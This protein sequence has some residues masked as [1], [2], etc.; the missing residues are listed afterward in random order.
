MHEWVYQPG[1]PLISVA[2][3]SHKNAMGA[4]QER[5]FLLNKSDQP[6]A[7]DTIW[8]VPLGFRHVE[9]GHS[10][11]DIERSLL[12]E[13]RG[14]IELKGDPPFLANAAADGYYRVRYTPSALKALS[15]D[16]QNSLTVSE[17]ASLLSDQFALA[18][19]GQMPLQDYLTLTEQF[20][21]EN[22][23]AVIGVI[24]A[25]LGYLDL[26]VSDKSRSLFQAFVRDRLGGIK[27]KLGWAETSPDE[28]DL[29]KEARADVL[30]TLGTIGQD[31]TTIKEARDAFKKY[32]ADRKSLAPDLVSPVITIVAYNGSEGD[33]NALSN[34]WHSAT[35]PSQERQLLLSLA[36]FRQPALIEKTLAMALTSAV[37]SQD[38]PFLVSGIARTAAGRYFAWKFITSHW[39]ALNQHFPEH[40][41]PRMVHG[42][43][44]LI[45]SRDEQ[46]FRAFFEANPMPFGTRTIAKTAESI[47]I[48]A[49]FRDRS[50]S[51][52]SSWLAANLETKRDKV[53]PS[54]HQ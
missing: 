11:H 4:E 46:E 47:A 29:A 27:A 6:R 24:T 44:S 16:A 15:Q 34:L 7:F 43:A 42:A 5:F 22:D 45:T 30:T 9:A 18:V 12:T 1:Y 31:E 8:Q 54:M 41:V 37:R 39:H 49:Q 20:R 25:Q 48:N 13:K 17:R 35:T 26:V 19:G 36:N 10:V 50:G 51:D 21:N 23:P 53:Q 14:E 38:G 40:M 52:L 33:Y 3:L 28:S 2:M 32:K